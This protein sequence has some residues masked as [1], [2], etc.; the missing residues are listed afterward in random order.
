ME[1]VVYFLQHKILKSFKFIEKFSE[2]TPFSMVIMLFLTPLYL[3]F[4]LNENE[5][6]YLQLAKQFMDSDWIPNSRNLQELPGSRIIYQTVLGTILKYLS[7]EITV[8]IFRFLLIIIYS[9]V[10]AKIFIKLNIRKIE[11]LFLLALFICFFKQSLFA[12]SWMLISVEAKSFAY[13]FVL[14]SVYH[15]LKK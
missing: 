7:F 1:K 15:L 5:E 12:G 10:L 3:S 4:V 6:Q 2:K 14:I 11:A 9:W 8:F 13:L